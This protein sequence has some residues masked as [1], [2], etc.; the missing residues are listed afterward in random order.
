MLL[1]CVILG[2]AVG[3]GNWMGHQSDEQQQKEDLLTTTDSVGESES[4]AATGGAV[5]GCCYCCCSCST[6]SITP[7]P[8]PSPIDTKQEIV[9]QGNA[10]L[11]FHDDR[12]L[13]VAEENNKNMQQQENQPTTQTSKLALTIPAS[14]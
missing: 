7:S 1:N 12:Q 8:S 13:T 11:P 4:V 10:I 6:S 14:C 9:T 2:L 5:S 3:D